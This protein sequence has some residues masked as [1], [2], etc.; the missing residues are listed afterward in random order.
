MGLW[1]FLLI[2]LVIIIFGIFIRNKIVLHF[3]ATKRA[4]A[5]VATYERQKLKVLDELAP[6]VE[7]V[8]YTH[9]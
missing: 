8:S 3:N 4:W 2:I 6:M 7:P 9:L 5:D 1:I